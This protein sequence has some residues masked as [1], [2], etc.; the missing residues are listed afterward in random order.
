MEHKQVLEEAIQKFGQKS[1]LIK[2][3]EEMG[4]LQIEIAKILNADA[5]ELTIIDEIA[6]VAIMLQQLT[7]IYGEDLVSQRINYKIDRL[8]KRIS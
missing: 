7:L 5:R 1:Q 3:I 2:T 8:K 6:D 4:E